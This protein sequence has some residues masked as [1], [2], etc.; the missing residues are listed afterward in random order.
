[1]SHGAGAR[2]TPHTG[3]RLPACLRCS[4]WIA[5]GPQARGER[6][7]AWPQRSGASRAGRP[8]RMGRGVQNGPFRISF[9]KDYQFSGENSGLSEAERKVLMR[10]WCPVSAKSTTIV[11]A[12]PAFGPRIGFLQASFVWRRTTHP[13][14]TRLSRL[15]ER[16][17]QARRS[18]Y[19]REGTDYRVPSKLFVETGRASWN[20][21]LVNWWGRTG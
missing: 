16:S 10:T 20:K 5:P 21:M 1:M 13:P 11:E 18:C 3:Q 15:L 7:L 9:L 4:G 6:E 12:C 14:Q 19:S 2:A 17:G 8:G